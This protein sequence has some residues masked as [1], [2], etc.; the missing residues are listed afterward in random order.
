M[1]RAWLIRAGK[2]G[3]R[4]QW[5]L[6][7]GVSGGGFHEVPDLAPATTRLALG[8]VV[9][10]AFAGG[11][12]GRISNF[13][14][15]L[16]AL[17]D[18]MAVG[19]HVV[20]P[21]KST[22]HLAIG[23]ITGGYA[24]LDDPDPDLRHVRPVDWLSTDVP[25]TSVKQDLLHS[26]GAFLTICEVQRHDAAKRIAVLATGA[27]DPGSSAAAVVTAPGVSAAG[28]MELSDET[29]SAVDIEQYALDRL[30][31][32]L[33]ETFAGHRMQD[34]VA[35]VLEAEGFTCTVPPPGPDGGVDVL[36]G[37]GPL[38]LDEPRLVVQ[39]K[40]E[41]GAV[42]SPVVQQLMGAMNSHQTSQGLL[43]AWG[44]ITKQARQL[45]ANQYFR[46]RVWSSAELLE[47]L[48]RTYE[49]LPEDIR[50]EVPLKRVWSLV[51]DVG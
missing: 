22:P 5:A 11:K 36:A 33:I 28:D 49:R 21:L 7:K 23:R 9:G 2:F 10:A 35:A 50:T 24:Y 37:T 27:P 8:S 48:F 16:W 20:M 25:R 39:V 46:V 26:L 1:T 47:A 43:V 15:Q 18:R 38:G 4:E 12:A 41:A 40:S 34:L 3:E 14:G 51:E 32:H 30:S 6:S 17:R 42:G 31:A 19:D 13:T 45:L 44:G 29:T